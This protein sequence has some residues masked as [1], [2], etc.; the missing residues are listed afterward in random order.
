MA[1][2]ARR[3]R[4]SPVARAK[5]AVTA[6]SPA[7]PWQKVGE[8]ALATSAGLARAADNAAEDRSRCRAPAPPRA[9]PA[10]RRAAATPG[11]P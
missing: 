10:S 1:A 2:A 11:P 5:V 3:N 8:S 9:S 4:S 7:R 6:S